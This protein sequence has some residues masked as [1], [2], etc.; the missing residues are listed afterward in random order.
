MHKYLPC[1]LF[2]QLFV[3]HLNNTVKEAAQTRQCRW[4]LSHAVPLAPEPHRATGTLATPALRQPCAARAVVPPASAAGCCV[5][6]AGGCHPP[7]PPPRSTGAPH[8]L[9]TTPSLPPTADAQPAPVGCV[10]TACHR[11]CLCLWWHKKAKQSSRRPF[12]RS[13]HKKRETLK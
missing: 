1:Q 10:G 3:H 2:A 5:D 9:P 11:P 8:P 4:H 7:T 13:S 12:R 6:C